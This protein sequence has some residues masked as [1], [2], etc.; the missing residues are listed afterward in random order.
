MTSYRH[1]ALHCRVCGTRL[2]AA[3]G[4]NT[5]GYPDDG[6]FTVC[7]YCGELSCYV[8]GPFGVAMREPTMDEMAEFHRDYAEVA[9][10]LAQ[11]RAQ[12]GLNWDTA[13]PPG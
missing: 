10:Q 4:V 3:T 13:Q 6:S 7:F 1:N 8:V 5:N 9:T 12:R 2:D 11:Y